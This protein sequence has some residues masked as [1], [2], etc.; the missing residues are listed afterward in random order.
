MHSLNE[1][2]T[3]G[4]SSSA[5]SA[6]PSPMALLDDL[7]ME[8]SEAYYFDGPEAALV[9]VANAS[10]MLAPLIAAGELAASLVWDMLSEVSE[11]LTLVRTFGHWSRS[12]SDGLW[13]Q[14][15]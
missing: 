11:N 6:P 15:L 7:R 14:N 9:P 2:P 4:K 10:M 3:P 5:T 8:V 13:S 12:G 1:S